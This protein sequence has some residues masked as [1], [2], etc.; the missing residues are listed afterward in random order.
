L[1]AALTFAANN[2]P[3]FPCEAVGKAPLTAHGFKDATT[4]PERIKRWWTK[5]P[6][7]M[8]GFPTGHD[9]FCVDLDR[10]E[11]DKDGPTT[12]AAL[13]A[14]HGAVPAIRSTETPSTGRHLF[15]K[16]RPGYRNIPLNKLAP[17]IEIKAR[18]GYVI[19]PPSRLADGREY[20]ANGCDEIAEAPAWL[21]EMMSSHYAGHR[22][23]QQE[24]EAQQHDEPD[25]ELTRLMKADAE[26]SIGVTADNS[27]A[28][29]QEIEAAL[30]VIP[31]DDYFVWLE[32]G[33]AIFSAL[34][35]SGYGLYERWSRKSQKFNAGK[36]QAKWRE[37][38][39]LTRYSAATVFWHANRCDPGW[40]TQIE[41]PPDTGTAGRT[42][43]RAATWR[44]AGRAAA[45]APCRQC[46]AE[47]E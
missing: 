1:A 28:T 30:D 8:I 46:F 10:K 40:R 16:Q 38:Q 25:D 23:R 22:P 29:V 44:T 32:I 11:P 12:W 35:E 7:A 3:I 41:E 45:V 20:K 24:Q 2:W 9:V 13:V 39:K 15:F 34:G 18:G 5:W 4:N 37:C 17:G 27:P 26:A 31:S 19:L 21:H 14:K 6:R 33:A 42:T 36:C 43:S 47:D